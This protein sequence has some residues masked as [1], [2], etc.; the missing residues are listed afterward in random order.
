M[1]RFLS[2]VTLKDLKD[3]VYFSKTLLQNNVPLLEVLSL[4]AEQT[5]N[6]KLK[7]ALYHTLYDVEHGVS[8]S[9]AIAKHEKIFTQITVLTLG[10]AEQTGQLVAALEQLYDYFQHQL[11]IKDKIAA[12]IRY[13]LFVFLFLII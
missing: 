9:K 10:T 2:T 4:T 7:Q 8:L 5:A 13:P 11:I 3:W 1:T 12:A 6:H